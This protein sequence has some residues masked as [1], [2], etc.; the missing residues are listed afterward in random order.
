M[1]EINGQLFGI[2]LVIGIFGVVAGAVT[3]V[4]NNLTT[5]VEEKSN[6]IINEDFDKLVTET[7]TIVLNSKV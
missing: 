6:E 3:V 5:A 1:S 2:L 4:V 7:F